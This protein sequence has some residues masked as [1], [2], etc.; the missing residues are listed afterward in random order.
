MAD[1]DDADICLACGRG[2]HSNHTE[3]PALTVVSSAETSK[4]VLVAP[5]S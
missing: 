3:D 2:G 1:D 5:G 4:A